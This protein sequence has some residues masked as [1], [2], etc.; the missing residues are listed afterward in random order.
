MMKHILWIG[1]F[2]IFAEP[3]FGFVVI[4]NA[5][6]PAKWADNRV[7]YQFY[8]MPSSFKSAIRRSFESWEEV[9]GV[10]LRFIEEGSSGGPDLRDGKN[11]VVWV[12]K[13]WRKLSFSPPSN[14]LAVTLSS[15]D[16]RSGEIIDADIYFNDDNFN[17]A[18]IEDD[19]DSHNV[20]VQ[21]IATHEIG[22]MIG[23]D[24]SSVS[25][26]ETDEELYE[27]TM[28]YASGAGEI[29]RRIPHVDDERGVRSLYPIDVTNAPLIESVEEIE[30]F[31]SSRIYRVKGENFSEL[32]SFVLTA[33]TTSIYDSVS[34]YRTIISSSEAEVQVDT[35]GFYVDEG[36]LIAFN[37]P[38]Q[39]SAFY[40]NVDNGS[41][42]ANSFSRGGS[43]GGCSVSVSSKTS[44]DMI[45]I[46]F[47]FL[48]A[49]SFARRLQGVGRGRLQI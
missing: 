1:A 11:S 4:S 15:F 24:H 13:D 8:N 20:D 26:F 45:W 43:A 39:N 35:F 42:S 31:G 29:S 17:W 47:A 33:N 18:V 46:A 12:K 9:K 23:L 34:R 6:K 38:G 30:R 36:E 49:L 2:L 37:H 44:V 40:V 21:N 41:T 19:S 3:S 7:T 14:A 16:A 48:T 32:T 27:A 10:D 28:F 22:H 5:G 25:F